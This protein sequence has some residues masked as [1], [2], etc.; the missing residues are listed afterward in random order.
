MNDKQQI[1]ALSDE[2]DRLILRFTDEFDLTAASVIGILQYRIHLLCQQ[3]IQ[4]NEN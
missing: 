3:V 1:A 4:Q 2:L